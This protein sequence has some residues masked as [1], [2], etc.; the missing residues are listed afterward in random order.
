MTDGRERP[1]THHLHPSPSRVVLC[2][3]QTAGLDSIEPRRNVRYRRRNSSTDGAM[4]P[5][6]RRTTTAVL[7]PR[8]GPAH[9]DAENSRP[10]PP[11]RQSATRRADPGRPARRRHSGRRQFPQPRPRPPAAV[12]DGLLDGHIPQVLSL[13]WPRRRGKRL[14]SVG[15]IRCRRPPDCIRLARWAKLPCHA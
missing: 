9:D 4:P 8:T 5:P 13:A 1:R 14:A 6:T 7:Q 12:A 2:H 10:P 11:T 15:R 3:E